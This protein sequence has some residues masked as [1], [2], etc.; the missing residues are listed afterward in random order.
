MFELISDWLLTLLNRS[1]S[2]TVMLSVKVVECKDLYSKHMLSKSDPYVT[3]KV[4]N[5]Q[6]KTSVK[7]GKNPQFNESFK[8]N[9]DQGNLFVEIYDK[10]MGT[11]DV[12]GFCAI[13]LGN[14]QQGSF[15]WYDL[16]ETSRKNEKSGKIKLMICKGE[17]NTSLKEQEHLQSF[18]DDSH[19]KQVKRRGSTSS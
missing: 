2:Y 1:I 14:V 13:S 9:Q 11:D 5:E 12:L 10:D 4:G 6:K 18:V 15:G 17:L 3:I 19:K 7:K 16:Y 8:F